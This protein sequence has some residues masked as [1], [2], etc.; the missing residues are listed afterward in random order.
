LSHRT[1]LLRRRQSWYARRVLGHPQGDRFLV[2]DDHG[3]G[4]RNGDFAVGPLGLD[5]LAR[6]AIGFAPTGPAAAGCWF[7]RRAKCCVWLV[8]ALERWDGLSGFWADGLAVCAEVKRG[9][10]IGVYEWDLDTFLRALAVADVR[11]LLDVRRRRG[12]RGREYAWANAVRLHRAL[13]SVQIEYRHDREL[14]PTTEL[15]QLQYAEDDRRGVGKRSR[16]ELEAGRGS[17]VSRERLLGRRPRR[18]DWSI[19]R[20]VRGAIERADGDQLVCGSYGLPGP[21]LLPAFRLARRIS[22]CPYA[23]KQLNPHETLTERSCRGGCRQEGTDTSVTR[24]RVSRMRRARRQRTRQRAHRHRTR[25]RPQALP[26]A[27]PV[28]RRQGKRRGR[29]VP[30]RRVRNQPFG[31]RHRKQPM[32]AEACAALDRSLEMAFRESSTL[33]SGRWDKRG[34]AAPRG[35]RRRNRM[36]LES[37]DREAVVRRRLAVSCS[38]RGCRTA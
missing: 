12:V 22:D 31:E 6:R 25:R 13:A 24:A 34:P 15:R 20:S 8:A 16:V 5:P 1:S 4:D 23:D 3:A 21:H 10:T 7:A 36:A 9:C 30:Y 29:P 27:P 32:G 37:V 28:D 35:R 38:W 18:D 11:L 17:L 33:G 19:S 26:S 2:W 14:A